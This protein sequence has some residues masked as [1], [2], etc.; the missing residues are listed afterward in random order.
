MPAAPQ[1]AEADARPRWEVADVFHL[2][3]NDYRSRYPL[4]AAQRKVMHAIEVCRT[5]A[6]G[7]HLEQCDSCGFERPCF[8]SCRNRH[9]PKC[10]SSATEQ[11]LQAQTAELLPV[12]YFHLVFTLPHELNPLILI[13]KKV[14]FNIL[15]KA[16]SET[17]ADFGR[18]H[19]KGKIGF[20][21]VLHTWD[22][23]LLDHFHLHCL[24]PGGA[25]AFD[26]SRWIPAR[27]NF[28]FH[29]RALSI[30]FRAKFLDLLDDAR[31]QYQLQFLGR[32]ETLATAHGWSELYGSL[33]R[34]KWVVYAKRPF[35]SPETILEYLGRYTHRVAISNHRI[36]SVADGQVTFL[37]RGRKQDTSRRSMTM[38]AGEFI[39]RFLLHVLPTGFQRIRHFGLLANRWKKLQLERCFRLLHV[40]RPVVPSQPALPS[41]ISPASCPVCRSGLMIAGRTLLPAFLDSS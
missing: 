40:A 1:R 39:R 30:V 29:V 10:G 28:L 19:L 38:D 4:P 26:R 23:T 22:P 3:G 11:W 37:Y 12:G 9:C 2:Y 7:G 5:E 14:L 27:T 33:K 41:P 13:N 15:F 35:S 18:T 8:H 24:I 36:Q 21:A 25:L 17:L 6:L 16:V 34:K 20:L 31:S 32:A